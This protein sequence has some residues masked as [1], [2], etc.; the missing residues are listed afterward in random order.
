MVSKFVSI[1][2]SVRFWQVVAA[3]ALMYFG[4]EGAIDPELAKIVAQVLGASVVIGTVD[5]ASEKIG[6]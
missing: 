1:L 6:Q 2:K 4:Q 5:R 3:S